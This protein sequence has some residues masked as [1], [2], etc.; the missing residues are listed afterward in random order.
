VTDFVRRI[1]EL[2]A[3]LRLLLVL[4]LFCQENRLNAEQGSAE[5]IAGVVD[6]AMRG[7]S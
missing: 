3:G 1:G 5:R 6:R 7:L 4:L 2:L